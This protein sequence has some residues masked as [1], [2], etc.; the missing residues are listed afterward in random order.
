MDP[1][2]KQDESQ[3]KVNLQKNTDYDSSLSN[4]VPSVEMK[5]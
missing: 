2:L 4:P 5:V 1:Q 3:I